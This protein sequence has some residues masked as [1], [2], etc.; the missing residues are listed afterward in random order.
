MKLIFIQLF[1]VFYLASGICAFEAKIQAEI[2]SHD[3][4]FKFDFQTKPSMFFVVVRSSS[5]P[6][7]SSFASFSN[8]L[9]ETYQRRTI[10]NEEDHKRAQKFFGDASFGATVKG[11]LGGAGGGALFGMCNNT[12]LW[13]SCTPSNLKCT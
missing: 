7:P 1:V 6:L 9:L 3:R 10:P 13:L 4:E 8:W 5:F 11:I 12:P 2:V